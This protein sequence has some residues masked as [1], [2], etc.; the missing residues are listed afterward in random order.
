MNLKLI[1]LFLALSQVAL[2]SQDPIS[3]EGLIISLLSRMESLEKRVRFL[4]EQLMR[5]S[6]VK[7]F[8][9]S[10]ETKPLAKVPVNVSNEPK[11]SDMSS[12]YEAFFLKN[13]TQASW[14]VR[15]IQCKPDFINKK[16]ECNAEFR[17]SGKVGRKARQVVRGLVLLNPDSEPIRVFKF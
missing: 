4:E 3:R 5:Q 10:V 12:K 16:V 11:P 8:V 6:Q 17:V 15:K 14:R 13:V 2:H 1:I 9:Q 7:P